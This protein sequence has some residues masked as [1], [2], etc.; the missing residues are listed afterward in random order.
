MK[1]EEL[2]LKLQSRIDLTREEST[3]AVFAMMDGTWESAQTADFL[4]L[5]RNKK[6]SAEE[7]IGFAQAMLEKAVPVPLNGMRVLD[8]C[9][10]GGDRKNTFNISTISAFVLAG[11][12]IPV[13]KHGN[14]AA[15]SAC[16]SA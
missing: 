6:E 11:C 3:E 14:R 4:M 10:T 2:T 12:G 9:G 13:A 5:L 16:G 8:T 15:S 1:F 7:L